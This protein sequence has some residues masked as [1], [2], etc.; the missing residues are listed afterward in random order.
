MNGLR[1]ND[2]KSEN[3]CPVI[4]IHTSFVK[5]N[6]LILWTVVNYNLKFIMYE[7]N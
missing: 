4:Y 5:K 7:K 2:V 1:R 6:S 3:K